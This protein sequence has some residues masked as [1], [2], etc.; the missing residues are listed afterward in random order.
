MDI[1]YVESWSHFAIDRSTCRKIDWLI[2][3]SIHPSVRPSI[4]VTVERAEQYVE[5][6]AGRVTKTEGNPLSYSTV[7][8]TW[9]A[10]LDLRDQQLSSDILEEHFGKAG[11]QQR[12]DIK[13]KENKDVIA[14]TKRPT[15]GG[16][17]KS[18]NSDPSFNRVGPVASLDG[19]NEPQYRSICCFSLVAPGK[20]ISIASKSYAALLLFNNLPPLFSFQIL[21]HSSRCR[22]HAAPI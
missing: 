14:S 16:T 3:P 5:Y 18:P 19:Y 17:K 9:S 15:K 2:H 21:K 11:D 12:D 1:W 8:I 7:F 20:R 13:T 10:L 22:N 4:Q 6:L